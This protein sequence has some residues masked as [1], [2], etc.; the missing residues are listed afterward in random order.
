MAF[1]DE[2]DQ[3]NPNSSLW[4]GSTDPV[5]PCAGFQFS[6]DQRFVGFFYGFDYCGR[7]LLLFDRH[8]ETIIYD[9]FA[10]QSSGFYVEF[11]TNGNVLIKAGHCE[12]AIYYLINPYTGEQTRLGRGV[13]SDSLVWNEERTAFAS[14]VTTYALGSMVW[15]YNIEKDFIFLP[16]STY[17]WAIEDQLVWSPDGSHLLYEHRPLGSGI[18][19]SFSDANA[20]IRVNADTGDKQVLVSEPNHDYHL[21]AGVPR[22]CRLWF[23]DWIQV[24]RLPFYPQEVLYEDES[25]YRLPEV[26]CLLTGRQCMDASEPLAL[27]WQTGELLP[28][29][30][31]PRN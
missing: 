10:D 12:G 20:I 28:W 24:H 2:L 19:Y 29:D 1:I 31:R 5:E 6:S 30:E 21:C 13:G 23:G 15:G 3:C 17:F 22:L 18:P 16:E 4:E 11:L 25:F 27:N 14:I 26:I 9:S 8:T 7:R